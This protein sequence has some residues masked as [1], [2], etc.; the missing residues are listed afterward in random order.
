MASPIG[1][2]EERRLRVLTEAGIV[3][4]PL[5]PAVEQI[6]QEA[7]QHFEMPISLVTLVERQRL[8]VKAACGID[9]TEMPRD[10]A[11][12]A[13]TILS[14]EV[15]VIPDMQADERF[16]HNAWVTSEPRARFY[17][18]APLIYPENLRLGSL[19][20]LDT[21]PRTFSRGDNAEL[22][23]MADRVVTAMAIHELRA[24]MRVAPGF[25]H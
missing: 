3:A 18:G 11:F 1:P 21:Q 23:E 20:I 7:R 12:C 10:G 16:R 9:V 15:F 17:A 25:R 24:L 13:Y 5:E 8:V 6:C 4:A 14:D 2:H 22:S 19:C